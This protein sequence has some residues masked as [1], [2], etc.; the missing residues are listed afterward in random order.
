MTVDTL[1]RIKIKCY[2]S[3]TKLSLKTFTRLRELTHGP[4]RGE[5]YD[6]ITNCRNNSIDYMSEVVTIRV[7]GVIVAWGLWASHQ[8][9]T[10]YAGPKD[11]EIQIYTDKMFRGRGYGKIVLETLADKHPGSIVYEGVSRIM[12]QQLRSNVIDCG[13]Y[14][15]Y[16]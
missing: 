8:P 15:S 3:A 5:L 1:P 4:V 12:S 14:S 16:L 10:G 7:D 9:I 6:L 13:L 2:K 11:G